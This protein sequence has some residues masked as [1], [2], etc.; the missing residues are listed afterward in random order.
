MTIT[1]SG[2]LSSRRYFNCTLFKNRIYFTAIILVYYVIVWVFDFVLV[3][4][5]SGS[6]NTAMTTL[7]QIELR[8]V[9]WDHSRGFL[10]MVATAQRFE[11]LNPEVRIHWE[12]RSLKNLETYPLEKLADHYDLIVIHYAFVGFT[13]R[14]KVLVPLE[15]YLPASFLADQRSQQVGS[16][17]DSYFFE[18]HQRAIPVDLS[19]P[20]AIWRDDLLSKNQIALPQNWDE[21]LDLAKSGHVEIA[22]APIYCLMN[23]YTLCLGLGEEP[24][25]SRTRVV[26]D[27]IGREAIRILRE[28]IENCS[29]SNWN[30]NPIQVHNIIASKTNTHKAYSPLVYGF[31]NYGWDGYADHRLNFGEPPPLAGVQLRPTLGGTGIAISAKCSSIN[32]EKSLEYIK[33]IGD[34]KI[35]RTLVARAG[36]QPPNRDAW[37]DYTNNVLSN[38]FFED[39]LST[40]NRSYMRPRFPGY[41]RFQDLAANVLHET[42]RR[43]RHDDDGL[44]EINELYRKS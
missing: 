40:M 17:F 11:E 4:G 28:L 6:P 10:P 19:T 8:G 29:P 2:S 38:G 34:P 36:G 18:G 22:T 3:F 13:E 1:L 23:F 35:Q 21:I 32:L 26:S 12:K 33:F 27:S 41:I 42:L 14:Q 25:T 9:T 16:S 20:V 30:L 7:P 24:F 43:V 15:K 31:S 37:E 44:R 39:T 5:I